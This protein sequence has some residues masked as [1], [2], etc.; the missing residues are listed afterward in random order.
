MEKIFVFALGNVIVKPM[1]AKTLYD[2]LKCKVSFE[3]FYEY[4]KFDKSSDDIHK[5]FIS[6]E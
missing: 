5:G 1:N 6:T 2:M 4:F 3:M